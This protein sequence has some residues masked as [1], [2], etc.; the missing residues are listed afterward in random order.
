MTFRDLV[1]D[2]RPRHQSE[3]SLEDQIAVLAAHYWVGTHPSE[4]HL[5]ASDIEDV[6][7]EMGV[8]L[9]C[10]LS[11]AVGNT[12]E[13]PVINSFR[14]EDG[15][16]WYIIRQRDGEFVMGDDDFPPAVT[17]ECER[18]ISHIQSM[19]R[20]AGGDDTAVADGGSPPTNDDGQTLREVVAETIDEPADELEE[21]LRRG[22]ARERREKLEEVVEAVVE[23]EF[24]KPDSYDTIDLVPSARRYH[25]SEW[26]VNQYDLA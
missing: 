18:V 7:A 5:R 13:D 15:P 23:S 19:D 3:D 16:E 26:A 24:D 6:V 22:R 20:P 17:D 21:Y 25:F 9:D 4:P 12:D 8:D 11:T 14:P 2:Y 10:N 1:D